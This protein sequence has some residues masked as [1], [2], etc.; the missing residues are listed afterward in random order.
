MKGDAELMIELA[1]KEIVNSKLTSQ[2]ED[3]AFT[4]NLEGNGDSIKSG[5]V[6][7]PAASELRS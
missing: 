3:E 6:A 2:Q 5:T 4:A 1:R 7:E